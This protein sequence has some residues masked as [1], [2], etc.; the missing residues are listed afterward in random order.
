MISASARTAVVVVNYN[1]SDHLERL[2]PSL[3]DENLRRVLIWDNASSEA[4][5]TALKDLA[6]RD[7]NLIV[8]LHDSNIG[9]GPA[10]NR[11]IELLSK[12][13]EPEFY[14]IVNPDVVVLPGTVKALE[15]S[16]DLNAADILSPLIVR[17]D[18]GGR[19]LIW[20]NGGEID[21]T[22]GRSIHLNIGEPLVGSPGGYATCT[23]V[24]GAAIHVR[25]SAWLS[26]NG[27]N[28][29]FFLYCEDADLSLRAAGLGLRLGVERSARVE[30]VEGGSSGG[31]G[32][33]PVFYYYVQRN[34]L[35]L[36]RQFTS[37][38]NLVL[39][40]GLFETARLLVFP[41]VRSTRGT[42][43]RAF[44]SSLR[45]LRHGLF[46]ASEATMIRSAV[47]PVDTIRVYD[48]ARTA[49]L[50]RMVAEPDSLLLYRSRSYD[51]E[52]TSPMSER[53]IQAGTLAT[54][55]TL[56]RTRPRVV[57]LNE[58][59]MIRAWPRLLPLAITG[60]VLPRT[61]VVSY[62]IENSDLA[63]AFA[64]TFRLHP[65]V[66]ASLV[67]V[68]G[69]GF[70]RSYDRIAFG[71]S[72]SQRTY[73]RLLGTRALRHRELATFTALE[74]AAVST[75]SKTKQ[76]VIFLGAFEQYKGLP[77]LISAWRIVA[78][79]LPTASLVMAGKGSLEN[80][81]VALATSIGGVSVAID[82]SR[83]EI[84]R[85]LAD[86]S[87]LTL[88]SQPGNLWREQVGLPIVEGLSF[89]CRII[90]TDQTGLRE[91]LVDHGHLVVPSKTSSEVL[92]RMIVHQLQLDSAPESILASL[93]N[94]GGREAADRW[95]RD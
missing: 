84:S 77:E 85:L 13:C 25:A 54:I 28:E 69:G 61:R 70:A 66:A 23:F 22:A 7:P 56:V 43:A 34:R 76:S 95:M 4:E 41:L 10:V 90:T 78:A 81:A 40:R 60:R 80:E 42:R 9:F 49:H 21:R 46:G 91:W 87:H 65:K 24:S 68:L 55:R 94:V 45:G 20:F 93:P 47:S 88:L 37:R 44:R 83:D 82:P 8:H 48:V 12:S 92:A 58:P 35:R 72:D 51:F 17:R 64:R 73:E 26:L 36:Y 11:A 29:D 27:F 38:L 31:T 32:P 89:G 18:P 2:L 1:S 67:R 71:T 79:E 30:H 86:A 3:A 57:E 62:A 59:L 19:E 5:V 74:P 52:V 14:W 63:S 75:V 6:A 39:G 15:S 33:G 53:V 16:A 50:E